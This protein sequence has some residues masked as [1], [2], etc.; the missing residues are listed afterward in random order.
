[1]KN[2]ILLELLI[3]RRFIDGKDIVTHN[4]TLNCEGMDEMVNVLIELGDAVKQCA[5]AIVNREVE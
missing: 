1:M 3:E 2:K 5:M 4:V